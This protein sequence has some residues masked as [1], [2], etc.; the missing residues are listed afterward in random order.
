MTV[1]A[2]LKRRNSTVMDLP[3]THKQGAKIG[4]APK[5]IVKMILSSKPLFLFV[6]ANMSCIISFP[7]LGLKQSNLASLFMD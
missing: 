2:M 3:Q 4:V 6:F 5:G 7:S 1:A